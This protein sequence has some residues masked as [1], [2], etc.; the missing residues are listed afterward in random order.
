MTVTIKPAR[1]SGRIAAPPSKSMAHRSLICAALSPGSTVR[2]VDFSED[3]RATLDCLAALG[4]KIEI[5]GDTVRLG[6]LDPFHPANPGQLC[7]RESGSTLRFLIP[8]CL[9]SGQT[10]ELTGARRLFERPLGVYA[11]ICEGQGL[12]FLP[13]PDGLTVCGPLK[14]GVYEVEG[15]VSSQ[16]ISGLLFALPLLS[17]DS[18]LGISG[19]PESVSYIR[20]TLKALGDFGI[21]ITRA[22][23]R[24]FRIPGGQHCRPRELRVEGDYSNAAFLEAFNLFGGNVLVEGLEEDSLQGDR[25]YRELFR[26]LCAPNP[27]IDLSD[28][29]DL[30]PVLF[31]A[32]AAKNGG[33][34]TGTA[35]LRIKESDRAECMRKEL[36]KFGIRVDV[37]ENSVTVHPGELR[38]PSGTLC[39]HNDHR[40]V[41]ALSVLCSITGGRISG[42]EAVAKSYPAF[43]EAIGSLG[44][45]AEAVT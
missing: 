10:A 21:R 16:F 28:C 30:A 25:V 44:I 19:S 37:G 9:L 15:G 13:R 40:I 12:T 36:A 42:A 3:I 43:F 4:A 39:G 1:A 24:T 32:A 34:F 2:G 33:V 7:C 38:R 20:L 41:M 6:G 29:P 31:A 11:D 5:D 8:L 26:R 18:V 17:G 14:S 45:V 35:R 27:Q 22:D 23:E